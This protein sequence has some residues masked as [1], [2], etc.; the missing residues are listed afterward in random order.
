MW[1][2]VCIWGISFCTNRH[3]IETES[4]IPTLII[5]PIPLKI[6]IADSSAI[7][8]ELYSR[9][10]C[11]PIYEEIYSYSGNGIIEEILVQPGDNVL[12][13]QPLIIITDFELNEKI[14]SQDLEKENYKMMLEKNLIKMGFRVDSVPENVLRNLN[15]S[16][17][18]PRLNLEWERLQQLK[19]NTI[20][21]AGFD[22]VITSVYGIKG[23][24]IRPGDPLIELVKENPILFDFSVPSSKSSTLK[25]G[26]NIRL[27]DS[28][29]GT[30]LNKKFKIDENDRQLFTG[31]A[32][33]NLLNLIP[34]KTISVT[35]ELEILHGIIL[36]KSSII[37]RSGRDIVFTIKNGKPLVVPVHPK[38]ITKNKVYIESGILPGDTIVL[39]P[40]T[41]LTSATPIFLIE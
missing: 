19:Q 8:E 10:I 28:I 14:K 35:I 24:Y 5:E 40:P 22:G 2:G 6:Y 21:Q 38:L 33:N 13:N 4:S 15:I 20:I 32:N 17:N 41:Y 25:K 3:E 39:D 1:I 34:G 12:K 37:Y 7:A 27:N 18:E 23:K 36:P 26:H 29:S 9:G 16:L 11:K 31:I 30:I